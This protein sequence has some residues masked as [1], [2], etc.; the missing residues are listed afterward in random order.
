MSAG[1]QVYDIFV[2]GAILGD[3]SEFVRK[4]GLSNPNSA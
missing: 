2:H 1:V 4:D 3:N